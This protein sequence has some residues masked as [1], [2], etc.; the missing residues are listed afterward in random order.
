MG[1]LGKK[2]ELGR[3]VEWVGPKNVT[4]VITGR[5]NVFWSGDPRAR[6]TK[7]LITSG[8]DLHL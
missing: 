2:C 7:W 3:G 5:E 4:N 1:Q 6:L 8:A